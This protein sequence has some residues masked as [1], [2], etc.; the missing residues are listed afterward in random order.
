MQRRRKEERF[1]ALRNIQGTRGENGRNGVENDFEFFFFFFF[2]FEPLSFFP[3]PLF[4]VSLAKK[5][6]LLSSL[7]LPNLL[8]VSVIPGV[9]KAIMT[10]SSSSMG[11]RMLICLKK[12][13]STRN[14]REGQSSRNLDEIR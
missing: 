6:G 14:G 10:F 12:R 7:S 3:H 11:R 4:P 9:E 1:V 2:E 5:I 13:Q 8:P